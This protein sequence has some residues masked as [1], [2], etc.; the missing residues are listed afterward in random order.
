MFGGMAACLHECMKKT[1]EGN[2][3]TKPIERKRVRCNL[4]LKL[5]PACPELDTCH[6][7]QISRPCVPGKVTASHLHVNKPCC[8]LHP[9]QPLLFPAFLSRNGFSSLSSFSFATAV[10]N[11]FCSVEPGVANQKAKSLKRCIRKPQVTQ[12]L[13]L[14]NLKSEPCEL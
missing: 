6:L 3:L 8:R 7:D 13:E 4:S 5:I 14:Q 12:A 1:C 9:L 11:K 10:A 2:V